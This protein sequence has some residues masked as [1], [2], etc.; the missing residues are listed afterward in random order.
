[1]TQQNQDPLESKLL[2]SLRDYHEKKNSLPGNSLDQTI[3]NIPAL[4][5]QKSSGSPW[6]KHIP[7]AASAACLLLTLS[8][9]FLLNDRDSNRDLGTANNTHSTQN[10]IK[11]TSVLNMQYVDFLEGRAV[12]EAKDDKG[13]TM[14]QS[15][16]LGEQVGSYHVTELTGYYVVFKRHGNQRNFILP[17]HKFKNP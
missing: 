8:L 3:L 10:P 13:Q 7:W 6:L 15:V 1:M 5:E 2:S 14:S 9:A 17:L 11:K 16:G 12:L 4:N